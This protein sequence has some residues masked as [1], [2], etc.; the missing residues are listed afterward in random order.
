MVPASRAADPL[1]SWNDGHNKQ[2]I[3]RFVTHTTDRANRAYLPPSERRAVFD[4]DGTLWTEQPVYVEAVF[5]ADRVKQLSSSHPEWRSREPFRAILENDQA[6]I[7]SLPEQSWLE[8][9]IATHAGVTPER[10]DADARQWL[11]KARNPKFGRRVTELVYQPMLELIGH[12]RNNGFKVFICTGGEIDFVRAFSSE[13]YGVPPE[14]VIG[15]SLRYVFTQTAA[16]PRLERL[17]EL[18]AANYGKTKPENIQLHIGRRPAVA[19]G[20]SDGDLEMLQY[21]DAAPGSQLIL[22]LHHDDALR[23]VAYDRNSKVGRLDRALDEAHLRR[24]NVISMK[25]DF[26]VVFSRR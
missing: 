20:N 14:Q 17:P 4:N 26:R 2:A 15:S 3:L 23:E 21:T 18:A 25:R 9:W 10:F 22:L 11:A 8:L 6:G 24:W 13:L 19:V 7:G 5:V 16:G 12:L 1:P